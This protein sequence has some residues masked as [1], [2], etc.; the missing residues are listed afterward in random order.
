M[1]QVAG[2]R[3]PD[4]RKPNCLGHTVSLH[5]S[6]FHRFLSFHCDPFSITSY[7]RKISR[8]L[9]GRLDY[10]KT[11]IL[12]LTVH[13]ETIPVPNK[14]IANFILR[15]TSLYRITKLWKIYT[16]DRSFNMR[17]ATATENL[18]PRGEIEKRMMD[19]WEDW[20][21]RPNEKERNV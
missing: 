7:D 14:S 11:A 10:F 9:C 19:H 21:F 16:N 12:S 17:V 3:D 8:Q 18:D 13:G 20:A 2:S 15:E 1:Q 4:R 6:P 5:F